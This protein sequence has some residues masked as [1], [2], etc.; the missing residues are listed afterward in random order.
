MVTPGE[1][2]SSVTPEQFGGDA[3]A[4]LDYV[5]A[6]NGHLH[7]SDTYKPVNLVAA[8]KDENG[9]FR[10]LDFIITGGARMGDTNKRSI[11]EPQLTDRPAISIQKGKSVTIRGINFRGKYK[12]PP[13]DNLYEDPA[14][15]IDSYLTY[16]DP[17]CAE[18]YAGIGI[19]MEYDG[20]SKG[21]STAICID[22][23]KF[24]NLTGGIL[25]SPNGATQNAECLR[26]T[27][28]EFG[29]LKYGIAGNQDQEKTNVIQGLKFWETIHTV[30]A[31][32]RYGA[33]QSGKWMIRD[34]SGAGNVY[35]LFYRN[36]SAF[37]MFVDNLDAESVYWLGRWD[38]S[39]LDSISRSVIKFKNGPRFPF[40]HHYG[41][42][43]FLDRSEVRY[44]AKGCENYPIIMGNY[45]WSQVGT[46]AY[47]I[48]VDDAGTALV[49]LKYIPGVAVNDP[50]FFLMDTNGGYRG[51]GMVTAIA[52][53]MVTVSKI[54]RNIF[55]GKYKL[56]LKTIA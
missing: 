54:S 39:R 27:Q 35:Q 40:M 17:N 34:A 6:E 7:F 51:F 15:K 44:Y 32:G 12:A 31:F 4:A 9:E 36:S 47:S 52:D 29:A 38:T 3:Q 42:N 14:K 33:K 5:I 8:A 30:F 43:L 10:Q 45:K 41:D 20:K 25:I 11:I 23:C 28:I 53:D 46:K 26:F 18:F 50:V 1:F 19:D 49:P 22:N 2:G 24:D 21:G 55:S 37:P 56:G 13:I 48:T 16:G